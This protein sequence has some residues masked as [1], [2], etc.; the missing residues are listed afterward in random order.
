MML[1]S[2]FTSGR[3]LKTVFKEVSESSAAG[4]EEAVCKAKKKYGDDLP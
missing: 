1:D 3:D 2:G 4:F